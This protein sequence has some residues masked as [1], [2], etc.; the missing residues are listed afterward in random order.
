MEGPEI[1]FA[2]AVIDNGKYGKRTVRFETGR[3]AQQ[4]QGAVAAYLDE[5][6]MLLSATS[7]GKHPRE[8]FDFFPL[9]VDVE[10]RSYAAGKIPGSF[11]R[12]EGRPS[13]EAILVCR[14]IDRPLR[15]SF[16]D[17]LRN[18][19]QIVITV[20][21]I[22]P[23]E[24]YDALAINAASASTQISGLPFSGP[25]AGVRLALIGDQWVAFPKASQLAD[26][27]FDLTVAGRVVTD[28]A[29]NEDVA[30]MMVEAEAT[31]HAWDLIQGGATKPDEAIVAQGL[32]AAKPF[33]KSLVDAQA[34]LAAQ[35]AKEIQDFPVFP[36][37][38]P[39]VYSAVEALALSE[40][41]DVYKIAAKTE[42]QDADDALKSR[43]KEAIA[44]KVSAGELPEV[45]N[46]QVSAAYKS[47]TKKVVRGRI[48]TEQIRMDGR[49]LAD[50]RPLDAEVAVIPRVHG[51][52]IFQR[53][54]TQILG[55]TTLNMLKMEQQIDSLSPVTKKRYLHHYNFPPYSTG[56]TGRVGSPKRREIGHGFLAERA[57]VPVLPS[58][59]E[60]PYAI[61]QVSEALSS[62]GS[63][64]MGS[65]CASTL[66]LLNAG[67]PLKAPVAGIAMGLVSDTVDG[68]TRYA[69]LTDILGAEDALGDMDFKVAGTSEFVTAIQLD[70]KLDGIPST[71]LDAALKQAKEARSAILGV[72]NEAIDAP[73]EMADTAPRVI[74]VQIP[75]DKI[76]ELI[77]PKG[78]TINGIQDTTGA[79]ISIED[80][81]TVYIGAVDG[82]SAEAARAQVNAIANP[83]NPEIGDQFLG[84][85][86]KIATFGA[87]VSLLPGRDG[88]LHV[89]EVRKLAGGKR[90]ENV[91]DVL[92]VG[93]KV[94]VEVTKVDDRGKLSLAPVVADETEGDSTSA[95][96]VRAHAEDPAE[97]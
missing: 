47:V 3:L 82:P 34:K 52:A 76:G 25:I 14:L 91:E 49:G 87:F 86:V 55:V 71:V 50:I 88:L 69:A 68:Q 31:E 95:E 24:F 13:T 30:I 8:G 28:E 35:S 48:L 23:D 84:T 58:R 7:A 41:G 77:G 12:R 61:R 39:E 51:S 38:A 11:F 43:V 19:V 20:L 65:V 26:A 2:E 64:S 53:G 56:E 16:V 32:E 92:G 75:V 81:G 40:L 59:D 10:E 21:S 70:T 96:T 66:S 80:N 94:L 74:S 22:A 4:A 44:S 72:L 27:V 9:T 6:T 62:N 63:T 54:E 18:E 33:L 60:F 5:E 42:R 89:S 85:V 93:Q 83:T 36:P 15:P 79:D 97:G 45:A 1:K 29:G 90:V 37:Y 57:L 46:S 17:G 73:D 78:K 67:V